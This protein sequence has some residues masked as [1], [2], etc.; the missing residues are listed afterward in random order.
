MKKR[1]IRPLFLTAALSMGV[2][3]G[4]IVVEIQS[5]GVNPQWIYE[6]LMALRP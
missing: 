6:Q 3:Y 1:V 4:D 5:K 2:R